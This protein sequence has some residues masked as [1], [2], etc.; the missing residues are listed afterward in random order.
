MSRP[1][2]RRA[3]RPSAAV[4]VARVAV[5]VAL[6][7]LA[8]S[9]VVAFAVPGQDATSAV[10]AATTSAPVEP[11]VRE[12]PVSRDVVRTPSP[13]PVATPTP[14]ASPAPAKAAPAKAAPKAKPKKPS[15]DDLAEDAKASTTLWATDALNIRT[16]PSKKSDVVA[17]VAAGTKLGATSTV[18]D[19]FRLVVFKGEGRWVSAGYVSKKKP[20]PATTGGVTDAACGKGSSMESGLTPDAVLVHR[21]LC[22]RF[23][24]VTS[25]G[26]TRGGGGFHATGQAVDCMIS[27]SKV[28][29]EMARWVRAHASEL[30][31]SE[32][33]YSQKIWT[34]QRGREGWRSMSD[35]GSATA[36]HYD[37]V[38]VSVYGNRAR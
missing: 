4:R 27:D 14:T 12:Q 34:V 31:V 37:H 35:R 6:V 28:G 13:T 32:V 26:G 17:E 29:W 10:P 1:R 15:A 9:G 25:F 2:P 33:I 7:G 21:T 16:D 30:G 24:Q 38:H 8:T 5:P 11:V 18:R 23:P 3:L 20:D 36:N 19:G 22:A